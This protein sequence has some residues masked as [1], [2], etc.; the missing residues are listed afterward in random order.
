VAF[1]PSI[2][3]AAYGVAIDVEQRAGSLSF[4]RKAMR[5]AEESA[6]RD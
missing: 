4:H 3:Q 6:G 1:T 5:P 2:L